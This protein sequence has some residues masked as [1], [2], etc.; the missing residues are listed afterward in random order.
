MTES[1]Q[2]TPF[3]L[4]HENPLYIMEQSQRYNHLSELSGQLQKVTKTLG[5]YTNLGNQLCDALQEIIGSLNQI[6]FVCTN[7]TFEKLMCSMRDIQNSLRNHFQKVT[8][9]SEKVM[10]QFVKN[11][12]PN[13]TEKKKITKNYLKSILHV[14]KNIYQY[15]VKTK[16]CHPKNKQ[17]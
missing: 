4:L 10:K 8:N 15:Q 2:P 5:H 1:T 17:N 12:I 11:E 9:S 7:S 6:E 13:L 14:K 3:I 16:N